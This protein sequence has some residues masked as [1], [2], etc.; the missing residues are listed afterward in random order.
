MVSAN[1]KNFIF[2]NNANVFN[3]LN[4]YY[5]NRARLTSKFS[6]NTLRFFF[7]LS[8]TTILL[9]D[10]IYKCNKKTS[11]TKYTNQKPIS[12]SHSISISY[13]IRYLP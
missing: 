6:F 2:H 3:R 13:I 7:N 12:I 8:F 4:T 10:I 5:D 1:D 9:N 11:S